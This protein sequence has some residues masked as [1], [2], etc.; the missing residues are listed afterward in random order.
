M[1]FLSQYLSDQGV[2]GRTKKGVADR[3]KGTS[4]KP[5]K[6]TNSAW[7]TDASNLKKKK[8]YVGCP[9]AAA[10]DDDDDDDDDDDVL[11]II[12]IA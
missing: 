6:K 7:K 8:N 12:L 1:M 5:L 4:E 2:R 11:T 9:A 10:G 3:L